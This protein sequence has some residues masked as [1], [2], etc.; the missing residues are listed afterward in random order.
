M[1][2]RKRNLTNEAN[3]QNPHP[4]YKYRNT[5]KLMHWWDINKYNIYL[6]IIKAGTGGMY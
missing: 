2:K 4:K 1:L 6:L 3:A 5:L